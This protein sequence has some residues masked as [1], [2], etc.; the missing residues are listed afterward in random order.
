MVRGARRVIAVEGCFLQCATRMMQGVLPGFEP[1]IVLADG[2]YQF[3]ETLFGVDEMSD[4][5]LSA[6]A[7]TVA[8][9]L[10]ARL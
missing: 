9:Q 5:E 1:E 10:A 6:H 4:A 3:D 2:L 8:L 7:Q